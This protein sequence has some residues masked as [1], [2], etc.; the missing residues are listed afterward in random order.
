MFER[1]YSF[2]Y[3]CCCG[4]VTWCSKN[5]NFSKPKWGGHKQS[6][7][8]HG[9]PCSPRSRRH[10]MIV[11]SGFNPHRG[12]W[13]RCWIRRLTMII[14]ARVASGKQQ[15]QWIKIRRNPQ[16][17]WIT[18]HFKAGRISINMKCLLH[19]KCADNSI[20]SVWSGMVAGGQLRNYNNNVHRGRH[21]KTC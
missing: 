11:W 21:D 4:A 17:H 5:S 7:K 3:H 18:G 2:Y 13:S 9:S 20:V 6:L 19:K 8:G 14:F 10:C 12:Q 1:N 16:E 15:I